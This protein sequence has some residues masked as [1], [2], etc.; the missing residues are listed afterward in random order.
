MAG[1]QNGLM[2]L[3]R[4]RAQKLQWESIN[5]GKSRGGKAGWER[6]MHS[7]R[8]LPVR[9]QRPKGRQGRKRGHAKVTRPGMTMLTRDSAM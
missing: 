1:P 5:S 6:E 8:E 4:P 9:G 2:A 7:G 3:D